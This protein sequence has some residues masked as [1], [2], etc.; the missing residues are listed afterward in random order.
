MTNPLVEYFEENPGRLIDKWVHYLDIYHRHFAAL[1]DR[2]ITVLEFGVF[3]GGSLQMWKHYF[4]PQARIVGVDIN[5]DCASLAE[6]RIEI[7]IGDQADRAFLR[8]LRDRLGPIDIVIDD[9]AH[10][11]THQLAT[12]QEIFPAVV[13]DG[14]YLVEDLH[15]GFWPE[16]GGRLP[17]RTLFGNRRPPRSFLEYAKDLV[18]QLTAWHSREPRRLPV[19][20]FTR[21]VR[22]MHFYD[23]VVVMEKGA[24][25]PP[26]SRKTG[27]PSFDDGHVPTE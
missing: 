9:G 15:T 27:T 23:S 22:G 4:G 6:D 14:V 10:M 20:A 11:F 3:H 24:I 5:P 17:R 12:F 2:P 1:R 7:H 25:D 13:D 19:T 21:S 18:D 16:Y 8:S 26:T